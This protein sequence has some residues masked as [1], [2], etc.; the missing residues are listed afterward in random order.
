MCKIASC[1]VSKRFMNMQNKTRKRQS[2]RTHQPEA[3]NSTTCPTFPDMWPLKHTGL[4]LQIQYFNFFVFCV[5]IEKQAQTSDR[6]QWA[7]CQG[8]DTQSCLYFESCHSGWS[9]LLEPSQLC[10]LKARALA[11]PRAGQFTSLASSVS[12]ALTESN[13]PP[14]KSRAISE[15]CRRQPA[16]IT[17]QCL[18]QCG[19]VGYREMPVQV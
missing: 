16:H 17:R 10:N 18:S 8:T 9:A 5:L 13:Q 15:S 11:L 3:Q 14:F 1:S 12:T 4:P 19:C 2:N 7:P 6:R